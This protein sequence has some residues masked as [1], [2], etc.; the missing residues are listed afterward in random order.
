M[1]PWA[2]AHPQLPKTPPKQGSRALCPP[3]PLEPPLPA[4]TGS[5]CWSESSQH[6]QPLPS[7]A[8]WDPAPAGLL[9]GPAMAQPLLQLCHLLCWQLSPWWSPSCPCSQDHFGVPLP[10]C[11]EVKQGPFPEGTAASREVPAHA[12]HQHCFEESRSLISCSCRNI[13]VIPWSPRGC[14]QQS[15]QQTP[16]FSWGKVCSFQD[17]QMKCRFQGL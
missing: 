14:V 3:P 7:S 9:P 13:S 10:P 8:G 4:L 6:P 5:S 11:Q 15:P 12:G 16:V 1:Q 17:F 2:P